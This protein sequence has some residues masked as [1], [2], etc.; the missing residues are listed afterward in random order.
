MTQT[1]AM[2]KMPHKR[3]SGT[4]S[5]TH[6]EFMHWKHILH[7]VLPTFLENETENKV[8]KLRENTVKPFHLERYFITNQL[9]VPKCMICFIS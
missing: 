3:N 5:K 1:A 4:D 2:Y 9:L 7:D 6:Q 8:R